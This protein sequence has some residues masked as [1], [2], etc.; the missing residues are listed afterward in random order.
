M[1]PGMGVEEKGGDQV[2]KPAEPPR[3]AQRWE[4]A[5]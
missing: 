5:M 3:A 1:L 4:E 2:E